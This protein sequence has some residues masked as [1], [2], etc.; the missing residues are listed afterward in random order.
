MMIKQL[1]TTAILSLIFFV[2]IMLVPP[3]VT[4]QQQSSGDLYEALQD[5]FK[6]EY[7]S[8]SSLL[9]IQ[10]AFYF[11]PGPAQNTYSIGTARFGI[12]GNLDN[13]VSYKLLTDVGR[14]P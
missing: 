10:G 9:Q 7:F 12:S 13:R 1:Y 11:D 5:N 6:K 3:K 4:A 14:Q 2:G 8:V